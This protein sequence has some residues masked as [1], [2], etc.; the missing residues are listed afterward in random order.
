MVAEKLKH[1]AMDRDV[2]G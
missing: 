1:F 2:R